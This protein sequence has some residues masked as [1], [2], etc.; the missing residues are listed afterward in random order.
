MFTETDH[1]KE[2]RVCSPSE[3]PT[4]LGGYRSRYSVQHVS[5]QAFVSCD[6]SKRL[7]SFQTRVPTISRDGAES[8]GVLHD[9]IDAVEPHPPLA[10]HGDTKAVR[11]R[12]LNQTRHVVPAPPNQTNGNGN[13]SRTDSNTP[14]LGRVTL[15]AQGQAASSADGISRL[16]GVPVL[17]SIALALLSL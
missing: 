15:P 6:D 16:P 9:Q 1:C 10:Q 2:T 5:G 4:R 14:D 3:C 12:E 7:P 11:H 8:I 13:Q 17:M